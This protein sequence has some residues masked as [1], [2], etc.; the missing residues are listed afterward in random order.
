MLLF[1]VKFCVRT[2]LMISFSS[3]DM[4]FSV[5]NFDCEDSFLL[6]LDRELLQG[7]QRQENRMEYR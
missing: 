3:F 7:R 1:F 6:F 4:K 2:K 5:W